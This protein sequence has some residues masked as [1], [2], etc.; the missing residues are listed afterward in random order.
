MAEDILLRIR[1][2]F[3]EHDPAVLE[4]VEAVDRS[5]I[6]ST[7]ALSPFERLTQS[8]RTALSWGRFAP[9]RGTER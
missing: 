7:L 4:A 9:Q 8:S 6:R 3:A 1:A 2:W 5:L